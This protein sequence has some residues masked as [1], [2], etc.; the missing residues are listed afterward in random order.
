MLIDALGTFLLEAAAGTSIL[1]VFFPHRVLG[2]G[3]FVLHG[4]IAS[5]FLLLS[6]IVAPRGSSP[7]LAA[8]A[9]VLL[10]AYTLV[11]R[12]GRP[13]AAIPWLVVSAAVQVALLGR[14]S[15]AAK[16]PGSAWVFA[17]SLLG[18]LLFGSVLLTMNLGH[19]YLVARSLPTRLLFGAAAG[20]SALAAARAAYLGLVAAVVPNP[21]GWEALTSLDRDLLFF[22]FR[23]L[24]GIVGPVALS[25]F[26]FQ[27]SRMRSNQAATGLLYVALIFVLIGELLASY[28][29]VLTR[30]PA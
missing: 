24:W 17:G 18:A 22:L 23:I 1:L 14:V 12:S 11:A 7:A 21:D 5:A 19:W 28:L 27:T 9:L 26:V 30:F 6:A 25:Y 10:A 20:Y 13:V 8:G 4:A 3:F 29:T 2:K 15:T 16:A